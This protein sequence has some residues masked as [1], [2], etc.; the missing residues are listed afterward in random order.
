[1]NNSNYE[2]TTYNNST[3]FIFSD[4]NNLI[5][6]FG[7]LGLFCFMFL[8]NIYFILVH[9]SNIGK[10]LKWLTDINNDKYSLIKLNNFINDYMKNENL[11]ISKNEELRK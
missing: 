1:M 8:L 6:N 3:P 7:S 9:K 4:N 10:I 5:N 11:N 2:N